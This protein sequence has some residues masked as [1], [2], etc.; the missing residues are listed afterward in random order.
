MAIPTEDATDERLGT[1]ASA[2]INQQHGSWW[3]DQL[4][5]CLSGG[6]YRAA[7]FHL[8][9]VRRLDELGLV[10]RITAISSVSGGS[11]LSAH[12]AT[13]LDP[14]PTAP[15]GRNEFDRR[16]AAPF[17]KFCRH[18]IRTTP[19]LKRLLP[20]NWRRTDTA[21]RELAKIYAARLT[22]NLTLGDLARRGGPRFVFCAT[23]LS[24]GVNWVF[25]TRGQ[26]TDGNQVWMGDYQVGYRD[27]RT[28]PLAD[29]VAASSCFPP[30]FNPLEL[31]AEPSDYV[32]GKYQA[33]DRDE[34]VPGV[35][36]SDGGVYDNLGSQPA[37]DHYGTLLVSDGGAV[38][39]DIG[40]L[41]R[42]ALLKRIRRYAAIAERGGGS[43]RKLHIITL[44]ETG[45]RHGVLWSIGTMSSAEAPQ[46]H[47]YSNALIN[48]RI[49]GIRTDLDR[50]SEAEQAVLQN[51]GY[52]EL[53]AI[54]GLHANQLP[55]MLPNPLPPCAPP[56]PEWLDEARV[57]AA[58][59]YSDQRKV[60]FDRR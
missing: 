7:L 40:P 14:W 27:A 35:T 30:V 45:Q 31:H 46:G 44:M 12:L 51:H 24:F 34:L 2:T 49:D 17:E 28:F 38:F 41:G 33:D 52:L 47:R 13:V 25:D 42:F 19:F 43:M 60:F 9:A 53:D 15:L 11:I 36:L 37:M 48:D 6:G 20:S 5:L 54:A 3:P 10:P 39:R 32:N 50:F 22:N 1:D 57:R 16:V 23:D 26:L 4:A 29:A 8:G 55:G 56:F 18:N 58:L 21:V 59:E